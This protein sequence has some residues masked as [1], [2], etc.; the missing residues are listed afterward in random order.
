MD[1]PRNIHGKCHKSRVQLLCFDTS[2]SADPDQS[3][4]R[5]WLSDHAVLALQFSDRVQSLLT[6]VH[7]HL[8]YDVNAS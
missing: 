7:Y 8:V 6:L 5:D 3:V 2:I 1:I 4:T